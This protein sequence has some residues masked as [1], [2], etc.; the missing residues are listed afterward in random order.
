MEFT[1]A[2]RGANDVDKD[3]IKNPLKSMMAFSE[4]SE[5]NRTQR[6][7]LFSGGTVYERAKERHRN[8]CLRHSSSF[9]QPL[10][11]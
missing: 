4:D 6:R 3:V 8:L 1:F 5:K 10:C 11:Q 7:R 9:L 2:F